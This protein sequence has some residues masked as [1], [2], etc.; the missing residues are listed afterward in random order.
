MGF[1][2][3]GRKGVARGRWPDYRV[4]YARSSQWSQPLP[5]HITPYEPTPLV[6]LFSTTPLTTSTSTASSPASASTSTTCPAGSRPAGTSARRWHPPTWRGLCRRSLTSWAA[7]SRSAPSSTSRAPTWTG[8]PACPGAPPRRSC[9]TW[10]GPRRCGL[11]VWVW[12]WGA[13][14]VVV[15][16]WGGGGGG[17][18]VGKGWVGKGWG[19]GRGR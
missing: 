7:W 19:A 15:S 8:S 10:C 6:S 4:R 17:E 13:W 12:W 11:C 18:G 5:R 14:G 3:E 2:E 1:G 16:G 9:S